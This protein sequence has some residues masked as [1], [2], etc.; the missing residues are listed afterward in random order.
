[1]LELRD[2]CIAYEN[3]TIYNH[4]YFYAHHNDLTLVIGKSGSGKTTLHKLM[5]FQDMTK[6]QYY[7]DNQLLDDL[8]IEQQKKFIKDKM[9]IVNQSP[10]FI[11]D[12][13]INDYIGLCQSL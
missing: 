1:M 12:L 6:C 3:Q 10:A 11:D 2:I 5:T 13:T 9:G 7:Y 4:A 8:S